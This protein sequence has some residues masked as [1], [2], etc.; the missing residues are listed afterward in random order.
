MTGTFNL[1][2]AKGN[3]QRNGKLTPY[4]TGEVLEP[5]VWPTNG[6]PSRYGMVDFENDE[7]GTEMVIRVRPGYAGETEDWVIEITTF[8]DEAAYGVQI[9]CDTV[10]VTGLAQ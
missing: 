4:D 10:T 5:I 9:D 7:G 3:R 1:K 8:N 2:E 6:D